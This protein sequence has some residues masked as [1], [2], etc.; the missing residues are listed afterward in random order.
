MARPSPLTQAAL[1]LVA[2]G[3]PPYRAALQCGMPP[4]SVYRAI[5]RTRKR[6]KRKR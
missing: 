6:P 5:A 2:K 3:V 1:A 4:S